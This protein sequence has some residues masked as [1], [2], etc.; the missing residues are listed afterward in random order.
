MLIQSFK[1]ILHLDF[2]T[3]F[4]TLFQVSMKDAKLVITLLC[5]ILNSL[6]KIDILEPEYF[7]AAKHDKT[8][9][10]IVSKSLFLYT[11]IIVI[12]ISFFVILCFLL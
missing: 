4:K 7:K 3:I 6:G 2:Y 5:N 12:I 8:D 10:N 9:N 11:Y 1:I